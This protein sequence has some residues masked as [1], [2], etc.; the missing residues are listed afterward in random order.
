MIK[1]KENINMLMKLSIKMKGS[2]PKDSKILTI[3]LVEIN[4]SEII[5][6]I[7]IKMPRPLEYNRRS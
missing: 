1:V 5:R 7:I 6:G 4:S 3:Q 2:D